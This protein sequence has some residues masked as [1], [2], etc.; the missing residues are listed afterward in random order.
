MDEANE[1]KKAKYAELIT[2]CRSNSWKARCEPVKVGFAGHSLLRTLKLRG[3][4]GL[5]SRRAIRN[6]LETA[7]KASRWLWIRRGDPWSNVPLGHKT[8]TDHP[9]LVAQARVYED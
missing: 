3:V 4:K 7:E 8:G 1:R 5:Q 9:S 6:T 2:E